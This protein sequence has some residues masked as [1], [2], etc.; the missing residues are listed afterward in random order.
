MMIVHS[1]S[2]ELIFPNNIILLK[3]MAHLWLL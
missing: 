2:L 1:L 3:V